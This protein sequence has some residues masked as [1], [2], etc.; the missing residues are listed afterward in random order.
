[1]SIL[2]SLLGVCVLL[3]FAFLLS[4][5]RKAIKL[6]TVLGALVIQ[7]GLGALVLYVP[8]GRDVLNGITAAV[9]HVIHYANEGISFMFGGLVSDKMFEVFGGG[10][11]VFAFRVLPVVVFFSALISVLYYFGIM[12]KVIQI[13]GGGLRKLLGTSQTESLSAT[14][15]IF[16]SQTEAPLVI[17]PYVA[18][19]TRSELFAVMVGGLASIAGSVMA[20]YASMGVEL[21]Y[22]IA[23][24][25]MAAPGGLL[26][27]KMIV[28]ETEVPKDDVVVHEDAQSRPAN[29]I[30]AAATGA[31]S[32]LK[33]A[34]NIGAMLIAFISLIALLNGLVGGVG[35][36][37]GYGD[38]TI[39]AILGW[40]FAPVAWLI[41]VPSVDVQAVGSLIGQKLILN[42]FVAYSVFLPVQE[43][44][45][46]ISQAITTFALCG[47]ANF[48]S[49]AVLL[50]GL[51]IIAPSRRQEVAQMGLRAVAA[52]TLANLMSATIAGL[53][54]G[55]S[56]F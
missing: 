29:A 33:L 32:G 51:G 50:G 48:A 26:M 27:A 52:G 54:I 12:Q 5:N 45:Q 53:F 2:M 38:I 30:D 47:F 18:S 19:M 46:P 14:A 25:F 31:S 21:K 8:W 35:G 34:V 6:R 17:K 42:E 20:G 13:L 36:W 1:M 23:A 40:V 44:M 22:L 41:G 43:S 10:G 7:I 49:I 39:Q 9:A 15:N 4:T 37:F 11:F 3:G 16:V 28:P 55:L 56:I 24:S